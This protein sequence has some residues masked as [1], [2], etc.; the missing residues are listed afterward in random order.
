MLLC[1][2]AGYASLLAAFRRP[3]PSL[4]LVIGF[5]GI[6][7]ITKAQALPFW[8]VSLLV[9][10]LFALLE[11]RWRTLIL[12]GASWLGS[13]GLSY[14]LD[15]LLNAALAGHTVPGT[16]I[17]GLYSVTAFVPVAEVRLR[18]LTSALL[19]A[20]PTVLALIYAAWKIAHSRQ[21]AATGND[22]VRLALWSLASSWFIWYLF[23]SVGWFRYL[24]PVTFVGSLFLAA[25]LCDLAGYFAVWRLYGTVGR[26][27]LYLRTTGAL[28]FIVTVVIIVRFNMGTLYQSYTRDA[29]TSMRDA[30]EYLNTHTPPDALIETY[31]SELLI[32]LKRPYHFPP[33]VTQIPI[34]R[35]FYLGQDVSINYDP[36][37]A[38][39]DY[40]VAKPGSHLYEVYAPVLNGPAFKM[41]EQIGTY[42]IYQRQR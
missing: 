4:L 38:D 7:L 32:F 18:T 29:D 1:L 14:L 25:L 11:R 17:P 12:I 3:F 33:D 27:R 42:G 20:L 24:F 30:A 21:R 8:T 41:I 36:L 34:T 31:D 5:W 13:L 40:L 10:A 19:L 2:L 26:L 15:W 23:F 9:P 35:R 39:P 28:L 6:A 22:I 16:P 37:A